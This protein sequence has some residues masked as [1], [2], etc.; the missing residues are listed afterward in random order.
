MKKKKE[1]RSEDEKLEIVK[2]LRLIDDTL[3]EVFISDG[4][5]CEELLQ[6]ILDNPGLR[7][8]RSTLVPQKTFSIQQGRSVR[9]DAYVE[10]EEDTVFNVEIQKSNDTNHVKRVRYNAACITVRRS[11]PGDRFDDIQELYI[12]YI[13][14]FD[15][16]KSGLSAYHVEPCIKETGEFVDNGL[17]QI[18]INAHGRDGSR[19]SRLMKHFNEPDFSDEEFPKISDK[20]HRLKHD[21]KEMFGMCKA[22]EDYANKRAKEY[23]EE[24]AKE[25]AEKQSIRIYI[26]ATM[27]YSGL[28][29]DKIIEEVVNR[30]NITKEEAKEYYD[31]CNYQE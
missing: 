1:R 29:E 20:V 11:E 10:G 8:D 13:T 22:V 23:A 24:Y 4:D 21:K 6:V 28:P 15:L 18:Y 5:A 2:G 3:F 16:F 31:E 17:H 9:V 19:I 7:I 27:K 26:E 30:F 25:Y 14:D 12:V